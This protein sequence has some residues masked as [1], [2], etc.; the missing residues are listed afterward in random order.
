MRGAGG[1]RRFPKSS[2]P[3]PVVDRTSSFDVSVAAAV[4]LSRRDSDVS[5]L[6]SS[7]GGRPST[8]T[9]SHLFLSD[10]SSQSAALRAVNSYLSSLSAPFTLRP[11]LPSA[12]DISDAFRLLLSRLGFP[13]SSDKPLD[14]EVLYLLRLLRCPLKLTRSALKAPGTPHSWP[15]LLSALHWLTQ[16]ARVADHFLNSPSSNSTNDLLLY[17]NQSYSL[18]ISGD[19]DAV[20]DLDEEYLS[21]ARSHAA[22]AAASADK[23]EK[24]AADLEARV[25]AVKAGPSRR[26][27]LESERS[28][29]VEDVKKFQAVVESWGGKLAGM[30]E[31][32]GDLEKEL[33][34]KER[35]SRRLC[36]ENEELKKRVEGQAVNVRDAERMKR[37]LQAVERDVAE[38]ET[39]RAALEEKAWELE[40]S[41]TRKMDEL[42][43]LVQQC[44]QASRKLKLGTDFQYVLNAQGSSP[45]EVIGVDYKTILKPA[46][47]ALTEDTKKVSVSKLEESISLQQQTR[48][49]AKILE[50]KSNC[51]TALQTYIDEIDARISTVKSETEDGGSRCAA[52]SEKMKEETARKEH[53]LVIVE[54]EAEEYL[55]N[56]EQKLQDAARESDEAT[57]VCACELLALIDSVSEYKEF[58]ESMVAGVKSD[59]SE[60]VDIVASLSA[61]LVSS[62]STLSLARLKRARIPSPN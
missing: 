47:N 15:P 21:K 61:K 10:R 5:S 9:A 51:S 3:H 55:R 13:V 19:D 42:E 11:P 31:A 23:L 18:F 16:L 62:D 8:T 36:E 50:E 22:A 34:A 46:L 6:C 53:Q 58:M 57:Q 37:E 27:A 35:E 45:A 12:R 25:R 29:L 60:T 39:G 1:R 48:E 56:S 41:I 52:E 28:V 7:A 40:A 54:K 30:E 44:N 24:E 33:D 14:D 59:L 20:A 38:A 4:G 26:E 17:I 49:N 43:V 2:L 32:V